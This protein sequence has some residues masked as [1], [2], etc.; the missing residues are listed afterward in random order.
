MRLLRLAGSVKFSRSLVFR[1]DFPVYIQRRPPGT[2]GGTAAPHE[3]PDREREGTPPSP[4]QEP[5][6]DVVA[7]PKTAP[8]RELELLERETRRGDNRLLEVLSSAE[9]LQ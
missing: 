7:L 8:P 4:G 5:G 6:G 3:D 2:V 1:R 9:S